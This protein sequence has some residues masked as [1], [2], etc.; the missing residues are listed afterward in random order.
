MKILKIIAGTLLL[1][2]LFY[3]CDKNEYAPEMVDQE[4]A[5]AE[6]SP[7]GT[8][9]GIVVASDKDEGQR[10]SFE[11][12]D[13]NEDGIFA[14]GLASGSIS[15]ANSTLLDYELNTQHLISVVA[16]DNHKKEPLESAAS[17]RINVS[18]QNEHVPTIEPQTFELNE[19]PYNGDVI[20]VVTASDEE[21]HQSLTFSIT[22]QNDDGYFQIDPHS[23]TLT[24]ADS[25]GFDY[26]TN[27]KLE[28]LV[29]VEDDHS[30]PLSSIAQITI[31][32]SDVFE[33]PEGQ[34]AYYPFDGN[35]DDASGNGH[36]GTIHGV[37]LTSD[38]DG[39]AQSA[40][41]FDGNLS[42]I[43]LGN[44]VELKRYMSDYTFA[45]WFRLDEFG[46]TYHSIIMS[47]RNPDTPTGSGSLIGIGGLQSSL[48]RRVE[49]I[50]NVTV[51][52]DEFTYD[53]MSSNTQLELDNWY[54]FCVTYEYHGSLSNLVKVYINGN[55]ESQKLMGEVIDPENINTFL[56]CEPQLSPVGY[57]FNGVMDDIEF[58]DR[59]LS[60]GEIMVLYNR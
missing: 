23:G 8:I 42:Y 39:N 31:N 52:G 51:T 55:F 4:F 56:G 37:E 14:I 21:A 2:I 17:I 29:K 26:E 45:G 35:A 38:R 32:I 40:Y 16:T 44:S 11:I 50:Q 27:E 9:V 57:S 20:G 59:A 22:T 48:S 10:L 47:N 46:Q 18:D 6:N 3:S 60:E 36:N 19:N 58:Y 1:S 53:Y 41:Y 24:V 43:D 15:V 49:Y 33:L 13:G 7:V 30:Q 34:V 5:I 12:T 54:F 28:I 25:T